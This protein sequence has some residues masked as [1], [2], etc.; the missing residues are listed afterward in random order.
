MTWSQSSPVFAYLSQLFTGFEKKFN[1]PI[2]IQTVTFTLS[3]EQLLF[4][5]SG[6]TPKLE[7][8]LKSFQAFTPA[9]NV[10]SIE[11]S[12][13]QYELCTALDPTHRLIEV[14]FSFY[15]LLSLSL[16]RGK[17]LTCSGKR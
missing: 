15:E 6:L 11:Y 14:L 1:Q 12:G 2:D 10:I 5:L 16:Q 3:Q 9:L 7:K 8:L 13:K 17:S 4:L